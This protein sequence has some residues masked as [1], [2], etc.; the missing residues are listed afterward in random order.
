MADVS[1]NRRPTRL[2]PQRHS[3]DLEEEPE[4]DISGQ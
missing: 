2:Y 1:T 3:I 4:L